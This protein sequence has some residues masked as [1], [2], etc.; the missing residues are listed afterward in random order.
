MG[1]VVNINPNRLDLK[2]LTLMR[3]YAVLISLNLSVVRHHDND[4]ITRRL[5]CSLYDG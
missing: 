4:G 3:V 1:L 2:F 5:G